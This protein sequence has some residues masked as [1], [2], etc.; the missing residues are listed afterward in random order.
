METNFSIEAQART[1]EISPLAPPDIQLLE[2]ICSRFADNCDP[3]THL[4]TRD[5]ESILVPM[6]KVEKYVAGQ[7]I[8]NA[9]KVL[10]RLINYFIQF[11]GIILTNDT[12]RRYFFDEEQFRRIID[13][14]RKK[15]IPQMPI[16]KQTRLQ[17]FL[18]KGAKPAEKKKLTPYEISKILATE[19]T[20]LLST[21]LAEF[22]PA[23]SVVAE[24]NSLV[25]SVFSGEKSRVTETALSLSLAIDSLIRA[26]QGA[27]IDQAI[28]ALSEQKEKEPP[29]AI[30][31]AFGCDVSEKKRLIQS[32]VEPLQ[33]QLETVQGIQ[34]QVENRLARIKQDIIGQELEPL[35]TMTEGK[36][37]KK[38]AAA[39]ERAYEKAELLKAYIAELL[40]IRE[41]LEQQLRELLRRLNALR[42]CE[43]SQP[44]PTQVNEIKISRPPEFDEEELLVWEPPEAESKEE[45]TSPAEEENPL[46]EKL[47]VEA[48]L[49]AGKRCSSWRMGDALFELDLIGQDPKIRGAVMA[50]CRTIS[51]K[52]PP[53]LKYRGSISRRHKIYAVNADLCRGMTFSVIPMELHDR[54]RQLLA[55]KPLA[56]QKESSPPEQT[57]SLPATKVQAARQTVKTKRRPSPRKKKPLI[58]FSATG[59]SEEEKVIVAVFYVTGHNRT[60]KKISSIIT[61][62]KL[63]S[64]DP[65][66]DATF[67]KIFELCDRFSKETANPFLRFFG[68]VGINLTYGVPK[69]TV[70][71]WIETVLPAEIQ[72][73]IKEFVQPKK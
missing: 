45:T 11:G 52:N 32:L 22:P 71:P 26:A 70:L 20:E 54:L 14:A 16:D 66:S 3:N 61:R 19:I 42:V 50:T 64:G 39:I 29:Q 65:S 56:E 15:I 18:A 24:L 49:I 5:P 57:D 51:Q 6:N 31:S 62:L 25:A 9:K 21:R 17:S 30:V 38:I 40:K 13:A 4:M 55:K 36:E 72:Q 10:W 44:L 23:E 47:L 41:P 43:M 46:L 34:T 37:H 1:S 63:F 48:Y 73:K 58:T 28:E 35:L 53:P 8:G 59:L 12:E 68:K 7:P 67:R 2:Q 27:G 60:V 69:S 33:R